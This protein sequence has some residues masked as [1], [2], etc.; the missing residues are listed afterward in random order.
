MAIDPSLHT[1]NLGTLEQEKF[2]LDGDGNVIVRTSAKGEFKL[3]GLNNGGVITEVVLNETTWTALPASALSERNAM[4]VQNRSGIEIKIN[5]SNSVSGYV[6]VVVPN[7][8]ERFYDI[9]DA[10]TIYAKS[11]NGTPTVV[12]EEIS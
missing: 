11:N 6:G 9:T 5:Y 10:I 12:V 2:S 3:T 7:N 8:G 1:N 4:S